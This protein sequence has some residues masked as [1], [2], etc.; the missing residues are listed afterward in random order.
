LIDREAIA[1]LIIGLIVALLLHGTLV[2]A[3]A[4]ALM[5]YQSDD[6]TVVL[7]EAAQLQEPLED[8][9]PEP[10]RQPPLPELSRQEN[11]RL[12]KQDADDIARMAWISHEA[13][14]KLMTDQAS[15]SL[16]PALQ[17]RV[18]PVQAA[19]V[20]MDPTPP[21]LATA[22]A[23]QAMSMP[24]LT[25]ADQPVSTD[26]QE[27]SDDMP[28]KQHHAQ[29][30]QKNDQ[31]Q[32]VR[33]R[34]S[35]SLPVKSLAAPN[36]LEKAGHASDQLASD[37]RAKS[38]GPVSQDI[39]T[40]SEQADIEKGMAKQPSKT[41]RAGRS[42]VAVFRSS[43]APTAAA[44]GETQVMP[45]TRV[46]MRKRQVGAVQV[47]K[48]LEVLPAYPRFNVI[49]RISVLPSNAKAVIIF[50]CN[51]TVKAVKLTRSTG[52]AGYDSPILESLYR[53]RAR[54]EALQEN[55]AGVTIPID[56]LLR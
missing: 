13:F 16:Q 43:A 55:D 26:S 1:P 24:P 46:D 15:E 42:P 14:E 36:K 12:G 45:T 40:R 30:P 2:P 5:S 9:Q 4:V 53:W 38:T 18:Q 51:G 17:D 27:Q 39:P 29:E 10:Q 19:P 37:T 49:S 41:S 23:M 52:Y 48:G 22:A 56:L 33:Q 8:N 7:E 47:A 20:R 35:T 25:E 21:A 54:G 34:A 31:P 6:R 50:D 11:V 3:A 44:T 28:A 32:P